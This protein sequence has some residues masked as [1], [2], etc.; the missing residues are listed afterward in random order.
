MCSSPV[1]CVN[2]DGES[3]ACTDASFMAQIDSANCTPGENAGTLNV[4]A[5]GKVTGCG[6]VATQLGVDSGN[7]TLSGGDCGSWVLDAT[8]SYGL[9]CIP[10]SVTAPVETAWELEVTLGSPVSSV[11]VFVAAESGHT[12]AQMTIAC[13]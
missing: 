4:V 8:N 2:G 1:T 12:F 7:V 11:R 10:S 3:G 6:S 13:D 5:N 9:V